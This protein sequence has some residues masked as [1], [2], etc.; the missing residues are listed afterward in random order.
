MTK[1]CMVALLAAL[2]V[3]FGAV[4]GFAAETLTIPSPDWVGK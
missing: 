4:V 2:A 3:L 1:R